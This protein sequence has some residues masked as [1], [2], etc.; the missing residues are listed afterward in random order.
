M[1][2]WWRLEVWDRIGAVQIADIAGSVIFEAPPAFI[3]QSMLSGS[4]MSEI[5]GK[6]CSIQ[7]QE[8]GELNLLD[9]TIKGKVLELVTNYFISMQTRDEAWPEGHFSEVV[10]NLY[11]YKGG[12]NTLMSYQQTNI[13]AGASN[14]VTARWGLFCK[15]MKGFIIRQ[16]SNL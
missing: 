10:Y 11:E 1:N 12:S 15:Q 16:G 8:N 6:E 2:E 3:Y 7:P 5:M 13:P 9:G 14:D 4:K